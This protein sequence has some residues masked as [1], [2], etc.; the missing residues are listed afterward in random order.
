MKISPKANGWRYRLYSSQREDYP[1]AIIVLREFG[2]SEVSENK[3]YYSPEEFRA[4]IGDFK[5]RH[6][7]AAIEIHTGTI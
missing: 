7:I 5:K 3:N 6:K 1:K 2:Y 4:L